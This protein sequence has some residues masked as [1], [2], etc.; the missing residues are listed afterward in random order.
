MVAIASLPQVSLQPQFGGGAEMALDLDRLSSAHRSRTIAVSIRVARDRL[1]DH[2]IH[3][4]FGL[5]EF[6]EHAFE[7]R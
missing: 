7:K 2:F 1:F 4:S 3:F 5:L 6:F